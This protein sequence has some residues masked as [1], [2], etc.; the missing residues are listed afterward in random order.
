[1]SWFRV[2]TPAPDSDDEDNELIRDTLGEPPPVNH[3]FG[4][5]TPRT[6]ICSGEFLDFDQSCHSTAAA[7]WCGSLV[8]L[9]S[10]A[11]GVVAAL[12]LFVSG[13]I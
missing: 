1:M 3:T 11:R 12:M 8:F 10:R 4:H 5:S 7:S 9:V 13:A 6:L 2:P